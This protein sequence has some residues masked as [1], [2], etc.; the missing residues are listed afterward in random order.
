MTSIKNYIIHMKGMKDGF[1]SEQWVTLAIPTILE[2]AISLDEIIECA[3]QVL[4]AAYLDSYGWELQGIRIEQENTVNIMRY[5]SPKVFG[6][7][8]EE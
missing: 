4:V 7:D 2:G 5:A 8:M 3:K 1:A 6:I